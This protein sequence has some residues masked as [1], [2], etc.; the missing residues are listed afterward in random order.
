M[1]PLRRIVR[2]CGSVYFAVTLIATV[3]FLVIAGTLIESH[4]DS[5]L[6]AARWTYDSPL[7]T[8]LLWLFFVNILVSALLRWPFRWRHLPFLVTHLG[9]L[10]ML[11]GCLVK[12]YWGTQG[13]MGLLEGA[14]SD[15]IFLVHSEVIQVERRE[16]GRPVRDAIALGD[17]GR[18]S[19][20][21]MP[22]LKLELLGYA[23]HSREQLELWVKGDRAFVAGLP[24]FPVVE[25]DEDSP[26]PASLQVR[27]HSQRDELWQLSAFRA[28]DPEAMAR[29]VYVEGTQLEISHPGMQRPVMVVPLAEALQGAVELPGGT[30]ELDLDWEQKLLR[31]HWQHSYAETT[32]VDLSVDG[33]AVNRRVDFPQFGAPQFIV[34]LRRD[35]AL[36]F[37]Q[38]MHGDDHLYAFDKHGTYHRENFIKS[39]LTKLTVYDGA[40]QGYG[41]TT[42]LPFTELPHSRRAVEAADA[43]FLEEIL[44]SSLGQ[45]EVISPPLDMLRQACERCDRDFATVLATYLEEWR[46]RG[47]WLFDD[48]AQ[49]SEEL[50]EVMKALRWEDYPEMAQGALWLSVLQG[51]LLERIHSGE[52]ALAALKEMQW[53]LVDLIAAQRP[54]SSSELL[55]LYAQQVLSVSDQLPETEQNDLSLRSAHYLSTVLRAYGIHSDN[56]RG[57]S[58]TVERLSR[59]TAAMGLRPKAMEKELD[60]RITARHEPLAPMAKLEDNLPLVALRVSAGGQSEVIELS[61]DP[62]GS[63]LK[64]PVLNGKYL[65]RFQPQ[66]EKLPYR[67]RLRDTRQINYAQS[68]QPF[69]FE[70]DLVIQET[71]NAREMSLWERFLQSCG[72]I[73][74]RKAVED[75]CISMNQVHE[76]WDGYRFY[77]ANITPPQETAAQRAQIVVNCDPGKYRL[78]YPGAC[79]VALG[80]TLLFWAGT[81]GR[82]KS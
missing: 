52:D 41:C 35:P 59:Y 48:R 64:W 3:T 27:M 63:G 2:F 36:V 55:M 18:S 51:E 53:P 82:T 23:P 38:D 72:V 39:Q 50:D 24:P 6:L 78:T 49:I 4:S 42:E 66:F 65:L 75:C 12:S 67:I 7:F 33:Y 68:G 76:T 25:V 11:G 21:Q 80:I 1:K 9:L 61:Y 31:C 44:R 16:G 70:S 69:S 79:F 26:L 15:E 54:E 47:G 30:V 60:T 34:D 81:F 62:H 13:V 40:Y 37:I 58:G 74:E 46:R 45:E 29:R 19:L 17:I 22:G 5:H 14:A 10:M 43:Y 73:P 77:M 28:M 56:L 20:G 71:P 57:E 8:T 32:E